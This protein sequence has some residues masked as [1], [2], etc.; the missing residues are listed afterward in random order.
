[1]KRLEQSER[2][3]RLTANLKCKSQTM[4]NKVITEEFGNFLST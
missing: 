4:N 2:G 3:K 1:M